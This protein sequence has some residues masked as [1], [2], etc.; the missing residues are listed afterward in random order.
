MA[1][2][3]KK[4]RKRPRRPAT[5]GSA[6]PSLK[7]EAAPTQPGT[8]CVPRR[9]HTYS[10]Q[11]AL[12]RLDA[13]GRILQQAEYPAAED[14]YF[15]TQ[16]SQGVERLFIEEIRQ[17][18]ARI[19]G[20]DTGKFGRIPVWGGE[21][22]PGCR[23]CLDDA[24][25]PIRSVSNCNLRCRFCYYHGDED[26][27]EPLSSD[28]YA[29]ADR[30]VSAGDLELMLA[31]V[32]SGPNPVRGISWV[33]YEPFAEF[34]KHPELVK[35]IADHGV[36]QHLYTNGTLCTPENLKVLADAGLN[37]IRFNLA[38]TQCADIVLEM[39]TVARELFQFVCIESPMIPEYYKAFMKKRERIL[40]TG[41]DHLH[42]AELH[43]SPGNISNYV[44]QPLYQYRDGYVSPLFSRRLTY[45]LLD[46]AVEEG[47]KDI[48]IYDC[49]NEA[50]FVRGVS[51][52]HMGI[53]SY[54]PEIDSLPLVWYRD[55]LQRYGPGKLGATPASA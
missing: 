17:R 25:V 15:M 28:R 37:E 10:Q 24:F 51:M 50:K 3:V 42:C 36:H 30:R 32:M 53:L 26:Q 40:A 35:A 8:G 16:I 22:T 9:L 5:A 48:V 7:A 11:E 52:E 4:R 23:A 13:I 18:Q 27:V 29:I 12:G 20:L 54:D 1:K 46:V 2:K 44:D 47:W 38:A 31:K 39:M 33:W 34:D 6:Q 55:A 41:V 43:L 49:S 19:P 45:D 14:R 21:L